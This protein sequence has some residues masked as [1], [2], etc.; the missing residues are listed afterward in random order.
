M[1]RFLSFALLTCVHALNAVVDFKKEVWPIIEERCVECHKA[2]YELNGELK[3]PKA[4]LR[5]DGAAYVM[6]G[7]DDGPVVV[8]NHPSRSP[9]YQRVILPEEDDDHMP[10]KGD[11]LSHRQKEVLRKWIAQ[12]VDFG[13]WMG[14]TDGVDELVKMKKLNTSVFTP[15]HIKFY[16]DLSSG[17][18]PLPANEL[19]RIAKETGLMIRPIGIGS[20]LVEVRVVTNPFQIGDAEIGELRPLAGH[21]AKLD[22]RNTGITERSLIEISSFSKLTEL[23]LRGTK[24]GDAGLSKVSRLSALQTLNLCQT[25]VSDK[26]LGWLKNFKSL[27]QVFLWGSRVSP[28][29]ERRIAKILDS[30]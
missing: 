4:G 7:G 24:I 10:P 22:L 9:L 1:S 16:N 17:L 25:E 27:R 28:D 13:T 26:G 6:H 3:K 5:L 19:A 2:P 12:G 14:A 29:G 20:P 11:L 23:N 15:E 21:L 18:E 8:A 30:E